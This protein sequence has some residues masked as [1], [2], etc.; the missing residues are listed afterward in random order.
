MNSLDSLL[1][2]P[3]NKST[4]RLL[5][6]LKD[7]ASKV[8]IDSDFSICHPDYK[9]F[10]IFKDAVKY[11]QE[12]PQEIQQKYLSSQLRH[13]IYGIY[14]NGSMH[15]SL[16]LHGKANDPVLKLKN[17]TFLGVDL[18]FYEQLH[19]SN[20]GKGYFE[21][22]W[23]ILREEVD[24]SLV[25]KKKDLRLH[26]QRGKHLQPKHQAAIVGDC[27]AVK[28]PK[29]L[30]QNGFYVAVSDMGLYRYNNSESQS[31]IV[32]VY[33]HFA[34]EGAVAVM[35]SLTKHLNKLAI[36]NYFKVLYNPKDYLRYDCGVLYFDKVDYQMVRE[37]LQLVYQ[38]NKSYFKADI[39]LFTKYLAPGLA[40]SEES[41][42][43]FTSSES[44][45][46]NRCQIIANGLLDAWYQEDNSPLGRMKAILNQFS[47]SGIDL[48]HPYLNANSEDI[49]TPLN[50]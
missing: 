38:E 21:P 26:I 12:M 1:I 11:I 40:A 41:N 46:M 18:E 6:I 25:V 45:G 50:L 22:G 10:G 4:E 2:Q 16:Q 9:P 20:V 3:T 27:V 19:K 23:Y 47:V 33:F 44:F 35:G 7:I 31:A 5:N 48:Q 13:F 49:Y 39:P 42:Q 37:V 15:N 34:L 14:Y 43:K 8:E 29:N 32:R 17:S 24:G 36:P 30:V 28:M